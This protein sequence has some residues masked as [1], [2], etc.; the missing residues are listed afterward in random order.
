VPF[1]VKFQTQPAN[2][3]VPASLTALEGEQRGTNNPTT[4][5][6]RTDIILSPPPR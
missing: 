5:F 2:V 1:V 4:V 3:T 6:G